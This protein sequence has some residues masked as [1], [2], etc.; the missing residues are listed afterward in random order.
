MKMR[1]ISRCSQKKSEI[2]PISKHEMANYQKVCEVMIHTNLLALIVM[3]KRKDSLIV[4][5]PKNRL[6][7]NY[8]YSKL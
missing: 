3:S 1:L 6:V 2:F 4:L 7:H 5:N 8:M